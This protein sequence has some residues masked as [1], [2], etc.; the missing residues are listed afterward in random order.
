MLDSLRLTPPLPLAY[1]ILDNGL[2]SL[3]IHIF[4]NFTLL[5]LLPSNTVFNPAQKNWVP[6]LK[7][8]AI[9]QK[10]KKLAIFCKKLAIFCK[11]LAIFCKKLAT[12]PIWRITPYNVTLTPC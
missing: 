11:K 1:D 7:K 6:E 10:T 5:L 8:L 3:L 2:V 4:A 12:F 9:Y